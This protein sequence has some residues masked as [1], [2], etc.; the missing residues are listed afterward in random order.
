MD[1]SSIDYKTLVNNE[2]FKSNY[3]NLARQL[4]ELQLDQL[5]LDENQTQLS[6]DQSDQNILAFFISNF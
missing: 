4:R 3:L 2:L 6:N 1:D 5:F